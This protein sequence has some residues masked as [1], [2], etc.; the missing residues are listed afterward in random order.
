[1]S[2]SDTTRPGTAPTIEEVRADIEQDRERLADT[3]DALGHRLDVKARTRDEL[4]RVKVR[5]TERLATVRSESARQVS[6]VKGATLTEDGTPTPQALNLT[7]A[8]ALG[9]A[10]LVVLI[11][12]RRQNT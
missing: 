2:T 6:R 8:V 1:M 10:A 9:V 4:S 3:V 12:W 5:A 7:G 11:A